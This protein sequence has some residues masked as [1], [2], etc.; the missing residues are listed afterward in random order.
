[1]ADEL[2]FGGEEAF[3]VGVNRL[4]AFV[5]DLE[6]LAGVLPDVESAE[7]VDDR[8]LRCIVRPG[9]SFLRGKMTTTITLADVQSNESVTL[10]LDSKAIG[11]QI[12]VE[13]ALRFAPDN[14]GSKL[15][16]NAQIVRRTGLVAAVS[17]GLIRAAAEQTIRRGWQNMRT[18]I[19]IEG[20]KS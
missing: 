19:E 13:A 1:M 18:A 3:S 15:I 9:V 14:A 7:R 16:W 20:P 2:S 8:T 5:T 11:A 6:S 17:S 12:G 10:H 4:F